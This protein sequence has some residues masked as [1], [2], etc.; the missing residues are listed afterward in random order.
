MTKKSDTRFSQSGNGC[1][2]RLWCA[3][4]RRD[5]FDLEIGKR[6]HNLDLVIWEGID[7]L[8]FPRFVRKRLDLLHLQIGKRIDNLDFV[9]GKGADELDLAVDLL[10]VRF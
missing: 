3:G 4:K 10:D 5:V 7:D 1:L 2:S 8:P 6:L 9:I